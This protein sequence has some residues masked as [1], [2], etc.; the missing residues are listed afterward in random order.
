MGGMRK[1]DLDPALGIARA[2]YLGLLAWALIAVI[3][4]SVVCFR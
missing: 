3:V 4:A 1:D 2:F